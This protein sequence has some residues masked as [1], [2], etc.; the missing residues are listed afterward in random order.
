MLPDIA[1]SHANAYADAHPHSH[2]YPY[3]H[4]HAN[5]YPDTHTYPNAHTNAHSYAL[6]PLRHLMHRRTGVY[7]IRRDVSIVMP[8]RM[9]LPDATSAD[10]NAYADPHSHPAHSDSYSH[11]DADTYAKS[12]YGIG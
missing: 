4:A 9:L 8:I 10:A 6:M 11:S 1:D 2:P 7:P 5:A 3:S 12:C